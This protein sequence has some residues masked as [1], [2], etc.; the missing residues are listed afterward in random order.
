[1]SESTAWPK[2]AEISLNSWAKGIRSLGPFC[3][4]AQGLRPTPRN[5]HCRG[6]PCSAPR[7]MPDKKGDLNSKSLGQN[8]GLVWSSDSSLWGNQEP[9]RKNISLG[10]NLGLVWSSDSSPWGNQE[11]KRKNT[12]LGQNL[13]LVWSSDPSLWEN[14]VHKRKS[15]SPKQNLGFA[16]PLDSGFLGNQLLGWASSSAQILEKLRPMC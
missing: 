13:G 11:H 16:K 12:R 10:R 14:Q 3:M 7:E 1:M 6:Q 8:L 4:K 9:K 5:D 15:I 2:V